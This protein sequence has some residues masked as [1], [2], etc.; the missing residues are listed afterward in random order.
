MKTA[1]SVPDDLFQA[2]ER[3]AQRLGL[4]RSSLYAK[5]LREFLV[6]HDDEEIT[7]RLD[8]VYER[9]SSTIDPTISRIAAGAL[10]KES[11]K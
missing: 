10:P 1:V 5:A 4:S 8:E 7:R 6:R 2:G 9:E 3:V 11:W